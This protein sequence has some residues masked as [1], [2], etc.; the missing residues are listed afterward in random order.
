MAPP[1]NSRF[2]GLAGRLPSINTLLRLFILFKLLF[3]HILDPG[4]SAERLGIILEV[5]K[6]FVENGLQLFEGISFHQSMGIVSQIGWS[7][8]VFRSIPQTEMHVRAYADD[9]QRRS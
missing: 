6:Q 9:F 3:L 7:I 8:V 1:F 2:S 4:Q 5:S